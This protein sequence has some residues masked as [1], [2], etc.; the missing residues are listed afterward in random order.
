LKSVENEKGYLEGYTKKK[1]T[2]TSTHTHA[3]ELY[4]ERI[5][6]DA[7]IHRTSLFK[8]FVR[9]HSPAHPSALSRVPLSDS[10]FSLALLW[11]V[12]SSLGLFRFVGSSLSY[13]VVF[14]GV[15]Q[16]QGPPGLPRFF[17]PLQQQQGLCASGAPAQ[18]VHHPVLGLVQPGQPC[19]GKG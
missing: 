5:E 2:H 14:R 16:Q 19:S 4:R 8:H 3:H 12:Y 13:H 1:H 6:G 7:E 9:C 15:V 17:V 11:L 10:P 18:F